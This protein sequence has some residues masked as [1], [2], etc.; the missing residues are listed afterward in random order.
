MQLFQ[1]GERVTL[2][3]MPDYIFVVVEIKIDG[4]Y[5]IETLTGNSASLNYDNVSAEML[6]AYS[7]S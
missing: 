7:A 1:I 3:S 4:S 2:A 6:K 5:V